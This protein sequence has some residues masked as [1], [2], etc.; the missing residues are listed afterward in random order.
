MNST[1]LAGMNSTQCNEGMNAFLQSSATRKNTLMQF[2][3][4]YELA[5]MSQRK[6]ENR[7]DHDLEQR[8]PQ[9]CT[10]LEMES[11]MVVVYPNP[12]F[13]LFQTKLVSSLY[14]IVK[15]ID[16]DE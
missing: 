8:R 4:R 12:I 9:F 14:Y 3:D 10:A 13:Y 11:Q 6:K 7:K 15:L 16:E 1:F 2:N 5:L